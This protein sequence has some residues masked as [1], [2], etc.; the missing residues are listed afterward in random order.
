MPTLAP[1]E[2]FHEGVRPAPGSM[3]FCGDDSGSICPPRLPTSWAQVPRPEG[4]R[5]DG[6]FVVER[7]NPG[8]EECR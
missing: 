6:A 5:T 1:G 4:R 8:M 2:L 7:V 3:W